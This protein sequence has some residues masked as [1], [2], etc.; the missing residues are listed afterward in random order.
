MMVHVLPQMFY[1]DADVGL[2]M[3]NAVESVFFE[4]PDYIF[5]RPLAHDN[6]AANIKQDV[7]ETD[8]RKPAPEIGAPVLSL[9][10]QRGYENG[11]CID[12]ER[13]RAKVFRPVARSQVEDTET[14]L[15]QRKLHDAVADHMNVVTDDADNHPQG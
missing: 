9:A 12:L 8:I 7:A 15:F 2:L 5:R 14:A 6:I 10:I 1:G 13:G 11:M 3:V 4:L